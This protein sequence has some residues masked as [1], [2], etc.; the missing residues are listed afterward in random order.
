[1][2]NIFKL[3]PK[4]VPMGEKPKGKEPVDP[5]KKKELTHIPLI[6]IPDDSREMEEDMEALFKEDQVTH[7]HGRSEPERD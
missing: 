7:K 3:A 1:M 5:E 2:Y 4:R 6:Q